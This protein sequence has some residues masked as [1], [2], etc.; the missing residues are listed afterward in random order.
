MLEVQ[1][2][3]AQLV[4]KSLI[5]MRE[6]LQSLINSGSVLISADHYKLY[7]E[8]L[9]A[10]GT[11]IEEADSLL[12]SLESLSN[13]YFASISQNMNEVMKVLTT[14]A[15]IFLPLTFIAGIYGMNFEYM[16]ELTYRYGYF[17]TWGAMIV[18]T[19]GMVIY[20]RRKRWV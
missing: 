8:L 13:I 14:E 9:S 5:P 20:F 7:K 2:A 1:K 12:R 17:F 6:A 15:T 19:I 18:V 16:P 4:K 10:T 3:S 11:A